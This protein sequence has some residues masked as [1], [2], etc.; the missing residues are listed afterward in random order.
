MSSY[1]G[2]LSSSGIQDKIELIIRRNVKRQIR[3][4]FCRRTS[5]CWKNRFS[6]KYN[7]LV[8]LYCKL[9]LQ[10]NTIYDYLLRFIY[11]YQVNHIDI[12]SNYAGTMMSLSNFASIAVVSL[13]PLVAGYILTDVVSIISPIFFMRLVDEMMK[14]LWEVFHKPTKQ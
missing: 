9:R 6:N 8:V 11:F 13:A 7:I 10:Y 1:Y 2:F 14:I 12:A 3:K 5:C 4:V